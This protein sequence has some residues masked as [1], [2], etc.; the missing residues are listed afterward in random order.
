MMNKFILTVTFNYCG[1]VN[2]I[3]DHAFDRIKCSHEMRFL[4]NTL[5]KKKPFMIGL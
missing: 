5:Q 3:V 4:N 1:L 2:Y